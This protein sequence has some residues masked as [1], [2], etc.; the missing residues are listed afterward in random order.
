MP[1]G[2][3]GL[4]KITGHIMRL[5]SWK[6]SEDPSPGPFSLE[7]DTNGTV[8]F[9]LLWNRTQKYWTSGVWNGQY[10]RLVPETIGLSNPPLESK[11]N[12]T[13][14]TNNNESYF[15][16]FIEDKSLILRF[17][18][19]VS[20]QYQAFTWVE[21][22]QQWI[23][24]W[25]K[26]DD[27]CQVY[28]FCRAFGI[29][30][31]KTLPF[32]TCLRGFEPRSLRD[33]ELHNSS[34]VCVRKSQLQCVNNSSVREENDW[35]FM[36]RNVQLPANPVS[37][38]VTSSDA[39]QLE[40][41]NNC[42][43]S[44]YAFNS[45]CLI[46]TG[47]LLNLVL[48]SDGVGGVNLY[49][50]LAAS[51]RPRSMISKGKIYIAC[52][53]SLLC[54]LAVSGIVF[55]VYRRRKRERM[56]QQHEAVCGSLVPF[57][58][59]DLKAS[60]RNFSQKLGAGSFGSVYKGTL[61]NS[62][63]VA[64]KKLEALCQGEKQFRA[65]VNTI[66]MIQ[67]VNLVRLHG[68]CSEGSTK[69]LVYDFMPNGSLD[70][71]LFLE[72][73][74]V[75]DWKTR[76]QIAL[77]TA[78][79]LDYL[80]EKCRDCIIHCDIKP[81]NILLD[82]D[83]CPIIA[84]FGMAKLLGREFSS[85][86]TTMRGTMGYLAPEWISGVS[87]TSKADVYSYGKML[88]EIISG[89]RNSKNTKGSHDGRFMFFPVWA[90]IKLNEGEILSILDTR[91]EGKADMEELDR[92][93]RVAC[94]CIQEHEECRPSMRLVVQILEGVQQIGIPPIPNHLVGILE[95]ESTV[96]NSDSSLI[97]DS[98]VGNKYPTV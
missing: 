97:C 25:S 72:S 71:H 7:L 32:C 37:L 80:H 38:T 15:T 41:L 45:G 76:Y 91:L 70:S 73:S 54:A 74:T 34:S 10:F 33:W 8:E 48:P 58:Y 96:F 57:S 69:M 62:T 81:E 47:D 14:I 26:P 49:L 98:E 86:L 66:G 44:A 77:G 56:I 24:Y 9:L 88:L 90:S 43:C 53:G 95:D 78:K 55:A 20:G 12:F 22:I 17:V 84:D 59:S 51:E 29:C 16:H 65:E 52:G 83:F 39:C 67:H 18:L 93:C 68:F 21:A 35:F 64:V 82:A 1:G 6:S 3:L 85:V 89:I 5:T 31:A 50:R 63:V 2:K 23:L 79:G 42:S 60:T 75:L 13:Y 46:W 40:C 36:M 87:I 19:G 30:N 11:Y 28:S 61:P 27:Q 92:A 4:N 94:W